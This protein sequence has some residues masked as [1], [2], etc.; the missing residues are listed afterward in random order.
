MSLLD[1]VFVKVHIFC[2]GH[3]TC[4]DTDQ[5]SELLNKRAGTIT[6]NDLLNLNWHELWKQEKCSAL[7]PPKDTFS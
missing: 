5:Y 7:A 1:T 3:K 6:T 2:E 4:F